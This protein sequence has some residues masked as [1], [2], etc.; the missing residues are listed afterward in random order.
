MRWR[1]PRGPHAALQPLIPT[2]RCVMPSHEQPELKRDREIT[3]TIAAHRGA[4]SVPTATWLTRPGSPRATCCGSSHPPGRPA[5]RWP[6]SPA[7]ADARVSAAIPNGR[8]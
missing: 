1:G 7:V 8:N 3:C 2:I 4:A 6:A 5:T